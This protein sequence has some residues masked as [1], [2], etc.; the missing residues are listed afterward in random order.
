MGCHTWAYRKYRQE[1][2]AK[3][4]KIIIDDLKHTN[5][6]PDNKFGDDYIEKE[7]KIFVSLLKD[8]PNDKKIAKLALHRGF[9]IE[10]L[11]KESK[12]RNKLIEDIES[13]KN[14]ESLVPFVEKW[15]RQFTITTDIKIVDGYLYEKVGFDKPCRIF[16]YPNV[17]F[18]DAEDF[19]QWIKEREKGGQKVSQLYKVNDEVPQNLIV[20]FCSEMEKAI[21]DFWQRYDNEVY[22]EFG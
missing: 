19:I 22:V 16:G 1:E 11:Q 8:Y 20:G 10:Y 14:L 12:K 15:I 17:S 13:C 6:S 2:L 4:K 9:L 21:R 5:Y 7:S 18:K 3:V